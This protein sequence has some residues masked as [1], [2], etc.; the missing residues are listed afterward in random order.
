[1]DRD[2]PTNGQTNR[3][4][5]TSAS[6]GNSLSSRG[7]QAAGAT[8]AAATMTS[9][10]TTESVSAKATPTTAP[11]VS[12]RIEDLSWEE[13]LKKQKPTTESSL[14]NFLSSLPEEAK[15]E[16]TAEWKRRQKQAATDAFAAIDSANYFLRASNPS[17]SNNNNNNRDIYAGQMEYEYSDDEDMVE[18]VGITVSSDDEGGHDVEAKWGGV[19]RDELRLFLEKLPSFILLTASFTVISHRKMDLEHCRCPL[20]K[21]G[22]GW[23]VAAGLVDATSSCWCDAKKSYTPNALI[24]HLEIK[25]GEN[26]ALHQATLMYLERLYDGYLGSN[27]KHKAFYPQGSVQYQQAAEHQQKCHEK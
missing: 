9:E 14:D 20:A 5:G 6:Q 25:A 26:N 2:G 23:R 18:H 3:S 11:P 7:Q 24:A 12:R 27:L 13:L 4:M 17:S 1:M 21:G 10:R 16:P 19:T 8:A 15:I 22:S